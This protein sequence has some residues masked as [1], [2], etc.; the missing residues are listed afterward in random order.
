M[1]ISRGQIIA[2]ALGLF[3]IIVLMNGCSSYN[4]MSE[5]DEKVTRQWKQVENVYQRRMDLIP[6]IVA[7]VKK[8]AEFER[9][10]LEALVSA[11]SKA[12]QITVS[13]ENLDAE[14]MKKYQAAQ[15][16][17]SQALGRFLSITE[18]YPQLQTNTAFQNLVAEIEGSENRIAFER[19]TFNETVED[20]N[21][22]IRKFP[23]NMWAGIFGFEKRDYFE[24]KQGADVA[25]DV[26]ALFD[27]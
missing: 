3:L 14:S 2:I 24:M 7:V 19:K 18:N 8:N 16:E 12:T 9:T 13:P 5:K 26:D 27:K 15:G 10:T 11:R 22:K 25:P 6:N 17:L 21:K 23:S 4:S 20:Y 1:K